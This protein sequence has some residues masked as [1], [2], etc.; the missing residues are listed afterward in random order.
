MTASLRMQQSK[1][2]KLL[3]Q[4]LVWIYDHQGWEVTLADGYR[5]DQ[6]GHKKGSL[7]Y[8]RLAQD[9]NLFVDGIWQKE[10]CLEWRIVGRYWKDLDPDCRWGGDFHGDIPNDPNHISLT[11]GGAA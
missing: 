2:A 8:I 6:M 1:F 5:P 9:L 10:D 7:H 3:G 11:F 4:L